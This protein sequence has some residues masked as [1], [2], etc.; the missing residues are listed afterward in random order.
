MLRCE[1]PEEPS[2]DDPNAV[3]MVLKLPHGKRLER[4]F[5][6][7][8]SLKYLYYFA[9]C[10]EECPDDFHIITNFPRRTLMCEPTDDN[11]E[12][13]SFQDS[14]LGK[15]EMLFVQDNDA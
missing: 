5:L 1:L 3:R 14:G 9:F 7:S 4:R 6:N 2:A 13:P 11:P 10:H 8:Q 12:P 15:N